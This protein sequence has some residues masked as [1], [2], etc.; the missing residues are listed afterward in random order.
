[1]PVVLLTLTGADRSLTV[2]AFFWRRQVSRRRRDYSPR[3][4]RTGAAAVVLAISLAACD[5]G[6][7][8]RSALYDVQ[9]S[10]RCFITLA[11][12]EPPY[13]VGWRASPPRPGKRGQTVSL[14]HSAIV[15]PS[16]GDPGLSYPFP[17]N[18]VDVFFA[19]SEQ[20]AR[21]RFEDFFEHAKITGRPRRLVQRRSN[22][23]LT[24]GSPATPREIATVTRCLRNADS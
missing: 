24:W 5:D 18:T 4:L 1:V 12:S 20:V 19:K 15:T 21:A 7:T 23:V 22:V 16:E 8:D 14:I 13:L 2:L 10:R 17:V 6:G 3:V 11:P 9:L